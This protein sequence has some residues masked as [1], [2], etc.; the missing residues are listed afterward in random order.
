MGHWVI[1][2]SVWH[3]N[4]QESAE[5]ARKNETLL[6]NHKITEK[7]FSREIDE[8]NQSFCPNIYAGNHLKYARTKILEKNLKKWE[9]AKSILLTKLRKNL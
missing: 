7:Q 9:N 1:L 8:F 3:N 2:Q 5:L 4:P 6:K